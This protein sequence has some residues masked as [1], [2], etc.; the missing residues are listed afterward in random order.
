[1]KVEV[2]SIY[3]GATQ[4]FQGSDEQVRNQLNAAYPF[5]ARY[6]NNSLQ[7]DLSKLSQQ[8]NLMVEVKE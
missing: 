3:S 1:M 4:T 7:D 6:K 5:L 2:Y 8:Q